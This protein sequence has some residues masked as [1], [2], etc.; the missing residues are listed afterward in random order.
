GDDR[1][2]G[3]DRPSD[4]RAAGPGRYGD[5]TESC[6]PAPYLLGGLCRGTG[7]EDP[8]GGRR[9][10]PGGWR[11][12]AAVGG[13]GRGVHRTAAEGALPLL[14]AQSHRDGRR[15]RAVRGGGGPLPRAPAPA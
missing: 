8:A 3:G 10:W 5:R 14:P 9:G 2:E 6:L 12:A 11:C 1:G 4:A 7:A 13:G 15:P